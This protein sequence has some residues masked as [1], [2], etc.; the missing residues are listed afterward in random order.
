MK[1][2][3]RRKARHASRAVKALQLHQETRERVGK[4]PAESPA[5][6]R[7]GAGSKVSNTLS[8]RTQTN[9]KAKLSL[10][11]ISR[12]HQALATARGKEKEANEREHGAE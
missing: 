5:A 7:S 1:A 11:S 12:H 3:G 4:A 8:A 6:A 10:A 9:Q 2:T